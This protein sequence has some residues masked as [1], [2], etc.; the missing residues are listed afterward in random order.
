MEEPV[1]GVN[2]IKRFLRDFEYESSPVSDESVH[3]R[4]GIIGRYR[5][6]SEDVQAE[7]FDWVMHYLEQKKCPYSLAVVLSRAV[8]EEVGHEAKLGNIETDEQCT[9]SVEHSNELIDAIQLHSQVINFVHELAQYWRYQYQEMVT[10]CVWPRP[11]VHEVSVCAIKNTRRKME[12]RHVVLHDLNVACNLQNLTHHSYYA[13]FDGH[14]GMEAASYAAAHLHWNIAQHPAFLTDT[15]TAVKEAFKL[16]DG[17]LLNRSFREGIKSGCTAVCCLIREDTLYLTWLGDSQAVVVRDG[18]PVGVMSPHKPDRE[19]ERL[20]IE[21]EGGCVLF[22][23]T[24]RVNGTLAVSRAL[25]DPEHKPYVSCEPD[26]ITI[27]LD[28]TEDFVV[29][30][31]DG[32]WDRMTPSDIITS[33]YCYVKES[34]NNVENLSSHLVYQAKDKGSSDNITA[35]VVFLTDP[36]NLVNRPIPAPVMFPQ[37]QGELGTFNGTPISDDAPVSSHDPQL[38]QNNSKCQSQYNQ[39]NLKSFTDSDCERQQSELSLSNQAGANGPEEMS[40]PITM[41]VMPERTELSELPTPP[42][43]EIMK[44]GEFEPC[45]ENSINKVAQDEGISPVS[46]ENEG[47]GQQQLANYHERFVASVSTNHTEVQKVASKIVQSAIESAVTVVKCKEEQL[48][49]QDLEEGKTGQNTSFQNIF[50]S[51]EES[52]MYQSEHEQQPVETENQNKPSIAVD[53]EQKPSTTPEKNLEKLVPVSNQEE[54]TIASELSLESIQ[55]MSTLLF[56]PEQPL[57]TPQEKDKTTQP[58]L[59]PQPETRQPILIPEDVEMEHMLIPKP[60]TEQ[61]LPTSQ[62]VETQ[63]LLASQDVSTQ[64]VPISQLKIEQSL[65]TP[66]DISTQPVPTTQLETKQPILIPQDVCAQLETGQPILTPQDVYAQLETEQPIL[67]PQDVC[68]QL[69]TGQPLLTPQD[70]S[71]QLGTGQTLLT[72][73]DVSAQQILNEQPLLTPQD[74]STQQVATVQLETEQIMPSSQGVSTQPETEQPILT[75]QDVSI[76][77]LPILQPEKETIQPILVPEKEPTQPVPVSQFEIELP[78]VT[79]QENPAQLL[80]SPEFE[81][82]YSLHGIDEHIFHSKVEP[83]QLLPIHTET[84]YV[85]ISSEAEHL[86]PQDTL[87]ISCKGPTPLTV[88]SDNQVCPIQ[89]EPQ[90]IITKE[91]I[92][93]TSHELVDIKREDM[94]AVKHSVMSDPEERQNVLAAEA[95]DGSCHIGF[96]E[97]SS[98]LLVTKEADEVTELPEEVLTD[99]TEV[100]FRVIPD[101]LSETKGLFEDVDSEKDGGCKYVTSKKK[102]EQVPSSKTENVQ[103][104]ALSKS[105]T[106]SKTT[107]KSGIKA[108][109]LSQEIKAKPKQPFSEPKSE[110]INIKQDR[111]KAII[112]TSTTLRQSPS[113][114]SKTRQETNITSRLTRT[115]VLKKPAVTGTV[116]PAPS[117]MKSV[118]FTPSSRLVSKPVSSGSTIQRQQLVKPKSK[119]I[120]QKCSDSSTVISSF[121]KIPI[122]LSGTSKTVGQKSLTPHTAQSKSE[123]VTK[124]P[125]V[126]TSSTL[127]N[128][129]SLPKQAAQSVIK[130]SSKTQLTSGKSSTSVSQSRATPRLPSSTTKKTE[131]V[132][133]TSVTRTITTQQAVVEDKKTRPASATPRCASGANK[134]SKESMNKEIFTDGPKKHQSST[135]NKEEMPQ[136]TSSSTTAKRVT[137]SRSSVSC[138]PMKPSPQ[139]KISKK[140][141]SIK[142]DSVTRKTSKEGKL[143]KE[144]IELMEK[145]QLDMLPSSI[146]EKG[147]LEEHTKEV[148][149]EKVEI[150]ACPQ[151]SEEDSFALAK[152]SISMHENLAAECKEEST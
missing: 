38:F 40:Q 43:D 78:T 134:Q 76:Q 128:S 14:A 6:T 83:H 65:L 53:L 58:L 5:L 97:E 29:L 108:N 115:P 59:T 10:T 26:V 150:I 60:E 64:P 131:V 111:G 70:V 96:I 119:P 4:F 143:P 135:A 41:G 140:K 55:P 18:V 137:V 67:T 2:V 82:E 33:I 138:V 101:A 11:P 19:D 13:I 50:I 27:N 17:H 63:L 125:P 105:L 109:K 113:K 118:P 122:G 99:K 47:L 102:V 110:K 54:Q 89:T 44:L 133:N 91:K 16:T 77:L 23:G 87:T 68:A 120:P 25:G 37:L 151:L 142:I 95:L 32:L 34:P 85:S 52:S 22:I 94:P 15:P 141:S 121:N 24:W 46:L 126:T 36:K 42:I 62:D 81:T 139:S 106:S 80:T 103:K 71:A 144:N 3:Y 152:E 75:P 112:K 79:S 88:F 20:R 107:N 72:S 51:A 123:A 145:N 136:I 35:I 8:A 130:P 73:Q 7:V 84:A 129:A 30:G 93:K 48:N 69:E 49:S 39:W 117:S 86:K 31:C 92:E 1:E 127:R 57:H 28:G 45:L 74:V 147:S 104:A 61:S 100:K 12:D 149:L 114:E 148:S 132:K 116:T 146:Q 21:K 124:K 66:Q 56:D 98:S 90:V 9:E